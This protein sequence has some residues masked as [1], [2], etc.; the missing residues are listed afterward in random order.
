M[1]KQGDIIWL[2]FDPQT[3][4]EQ[5]GIRPALVISNNLLNGLSNSAMVCPITNTDREFPFRVALDWRTKTKGFI[6]CD[7]AK[8]LDVSSRNARFIEKTPKDILSKSLNFIYCFLE[9]E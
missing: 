3:G 1:V 4:R 7:Q 8:I 2:E 5:K 6:Q 9:E